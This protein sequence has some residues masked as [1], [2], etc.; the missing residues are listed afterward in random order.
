M[1]AT[2]TFHASPGYATEI[3]GATFT[4]LGFY[5]ASFGASVQVGQYQDTTFITNGAGTIEGAQ[6][7]N[8]KYL[9][10]S[11]GVSI[12]G[13]SEVLLT[14]VPTSSGTLNVRFNNDTT[15]KTQ[16]GELRIFDRI[17]PA[18]NGASG[19]TSQVAQLVLG[20]SGVS[21]SGTAQA[22]HSGWLALAGTG[23]VMRLL[24]S[25]AS[26]GLTPSGSDS[27]DIRHDWYVALSASPTSIGS[28]DDFGLFVE[29][30]FL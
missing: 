5:G 28:K 29:L 30:E 10:N 3:S 1:A 24:N 15:V 7:T 12:D 19:V 4:G 17:L 22:T 21:S 9:G 27:R 20:G 25:P 11:S 14:A 18:V 6:A 23:T 13:G 8:T 26:G 16:N 2:I